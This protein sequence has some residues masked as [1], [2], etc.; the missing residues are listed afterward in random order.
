MQIKH[1]TMTQQRVPDPMRPGRTAFVG[2]L[3][4]S[5]TTV[6]TD[7]GVSYEPDDNG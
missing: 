1:F 6:L 7:D 2:R 3:T 4:P 5:G